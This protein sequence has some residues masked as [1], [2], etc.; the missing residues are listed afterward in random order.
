VLAMLLV[1]LGYLALGIYCARRTWQVSRAFPALWMRRLATSLVLAVFFAPSL[2][3]AGHGVGRGPALVAGAVWHE[4]RHLPAAMLLP[5]AATAAVCFV[6]GSVVARL[7]ATSPHPSAAAG[8]APVGRA[9]T[10]AT[11][12]LL[13]LPLGGFAGMWA[14]QGRALRIE[15][16]SLDAQFLARAQAEADAQAAGAWTRDPANGPPVMHLSH[17]AV[18]SS[19]TLLA[20]VPASGDV[21][22]M[23]SPGTLPPGT[24]VMIRDGAGKPIAGATSDAN[25]GFEARVTARKGDYLRVV[26]V[27]ILGAPAAAAPDALS[28]KP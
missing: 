9:E 16:E 1:W 11:A 3:P 7:R 24:P 8:L 28:P 27:Q 22:V 12:L 23:A 13:A 25:G 6:V 20:R 19:G 4:L 17:E 2:I 15:R 26:P 14:A 21:I 5:M 18:A 10:I